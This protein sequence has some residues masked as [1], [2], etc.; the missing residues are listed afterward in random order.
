MNREQF[1]AQVRTAAAA[2]RMYRVHPR[3]HAHGKY[4]PADEAE[5][6]ARFHREVVNAGGAFH[7]LDDG[8]ALRELLASLIDRHACRS[9]I[10]WRHPALERHGVYGMLDQ[11]GVTWLDAERAERLAPTERRAAWLAAD[12]GITAADF[13]IA[14]TGSV[15]VQ[16]RRGQERMASL[17]PKV[18]LAIVEPA[19]IVP[20]LFD[21]FARLELHGLD[22]LPSNLTLITGPS[23]TG[24]LELRLVTGVHGPKAWHV[25]MINTP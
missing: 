6:Q 1:L 22:Q 19:M 23:K 8:L 12:L 20:D 25:A 24:D 10:V 7:P 2:G 9:A 21:L 18:H 4:E 13:A 5:A 15:V 11:L 3:P 16:S 17:L 14:E